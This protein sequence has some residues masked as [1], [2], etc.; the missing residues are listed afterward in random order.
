M[1]LSCINKLKYI[2]ATS[3]D[4]FNNQRNIITLKLQN[5]KA[6]F[7]FRCL[8][9]LILTPLMLNAQSLSVI[10]SESLEPIPYASVEIHEIQVQSYCDENGIFEFSYLLNT[11]PVIISA[12]G[13]KPTSFIYKSN[14]KNSYEIKLKK[15]HI[16]LNEIVVSPTTGLVQKNNLTN[17][18]LK[19]INQTDQIMA[20]N[21]M[22]LVTNV[23][24]VYS[25]NTGSSISKPVIR[26]LSGLK[27]VTFLNGLRIENQQWA[28]DHGLNFTDMGIKSVEIVKGPSSLLYGADA[29]G[30]VLYFTDEDYL[31]PN[32]F[33][34][35]FESRFESNS[36]S[37][38]NIARIKLATEKIRFNIYTGYK[39]AAEYQIPDGEFVKNS[40][41]NRKSLKASLGYNKNNWIVNLRYNYHLSFYPTNLLNSLRYQKLFQMLLN[42]VLGGLILLEIL[43]FFYF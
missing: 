14:D 33:N 10:D 17:V 30:G 15:S 19:K 16:F 28:N 38:F 1:K 41:Y 21:L 9:Y 25:I 11:T 7:S 32:S 8:L 39:S 4:L 34:S 5:T 36:L 22:E 6:L 35:S 43:F 24:G 27:V 2:F 40:S 23:P 31:P 29:L 42:E 18:I 26:G 37:S 12:N 20:P 13:Y 3:L